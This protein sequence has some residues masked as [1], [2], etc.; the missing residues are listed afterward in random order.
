M[1]LQCQNCREDYDNELRIPRT[2]ECE[3]VICSPCLEILANNEIQIVCP[4]C[5][6]MTRAPFLDGIN[7]FI[8]N[9]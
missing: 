6:S 4:F 3:H 2:L 5:Q 8:H 7:Q 9:T 1:A